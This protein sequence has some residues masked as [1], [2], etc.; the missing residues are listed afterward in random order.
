MSLRQILGWSMIAA[1][2]LTFAAAAFEHGRAG[3][4]AARVERFEACEAAVT[5][6]AKARPAAEVCSKAI[7]AA[8]A[9]ADRERACSAALMAGNTVAVRMVCGPAT[10]TLFAQRDT[11]RGEV[12]NLR[13]ELATTIA[14]QAAALR[15]AEQAGRT[16]A[17]RKARRDA[18][19][20]AAPRDA[21]GLVVC[22]DGCLRDRFGR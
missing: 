11:A 9:D 14:G 16:Q 17:E 19:V 3:R 21:D 22:D 7:A 15:R 10:K 6:K 2:G 1:L 8:D 12:T 13:T 5:G 4:L 18:A 20:Q